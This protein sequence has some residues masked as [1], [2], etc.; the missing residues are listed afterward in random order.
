ML[1]LKLNLSRTS[2]IWKFRQ[3]GGSADP[4]HKQMKAIAK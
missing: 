3:S 4:A 1:Y 2:E